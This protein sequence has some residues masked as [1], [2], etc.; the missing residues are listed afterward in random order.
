MKPQK[1][2][3][4]HKLHLNRAV[5]YIVMFLLSFLCLFFF[6]I[7]IDNA[8][9]NNFDIQKGFQLLFA[10]NAVGLSSKAPGGNHRGHGGVKG[11]AGG[12]RRRPG[13][14]QQ[15]VDLRADG[16]LL[17]GGSVQGG[18]LAI[19]PGAGEQVLQ[20][21]DPALHGGQYFL[22]APAV[23]GKIHHGVHG[24]DLAPGLLGAAGKGQR[25]GQ[26]GQQTN[27]FFHIITCNFSV[28]F[29]VYH[30]RRRF[31]TAPQEKR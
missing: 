15:G 31:S 24:V 27:N 17:P 28:I 1:K 9:H 11:P 23:Y 26:D 13:P 10:G 22:S 6:Y 16:P 30:T 14:L 18:D 19:L 5:A 7:L 8:T 12:L 2:Y 29:E 3:V 20:L 25:Q 4:D 21:P